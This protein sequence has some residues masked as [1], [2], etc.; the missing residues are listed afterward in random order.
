MNTE[1]D[2]QIINELISALKYVLTEVLVWKYMVMCIALNFFI[3]KAST[4]FIIKRAKE[5]R[6]NNQRNNKW[7]FF[8]LKIPRAYR[9]MVMNFIILISY[10]Y[11]F[12]DTDSFKEIFHCLTKL[13]ISMLAIPAVYQYTI[14]RLL[15]PYSAS[16]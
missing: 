14:K 16:S 6:E 10:A 7:A 12:C 13:F 15:P 4:P 2:Q 1:L 8:L 11:L 5:F 3:D 9:A